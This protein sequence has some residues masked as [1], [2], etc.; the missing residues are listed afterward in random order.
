MVNTFLNAHACAY[1]DGL[2]RVG[3]HGLHVTV[4]LV[5]LAV[6]VAQ[7]AVKSFRPSLMRRQQCFSLFWHALDII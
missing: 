5:W 7:V 3:C 4:G 2:R 6:M 1:A